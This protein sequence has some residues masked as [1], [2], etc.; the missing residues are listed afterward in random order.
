MRLILRRPVLW[1]TAGL[2]VAFCSAA[3][4]SGLA[5]P[6]TAVQPAPVDDARAPDR[7]DVHL[8]TTKGLIVIEAHRDW[9]P[10]G[11]DRF[12]TLVRAGYYDDSRFFRVVAD[13]WAQ[14]GI[15]GR[16]P[17]A[18]AWRTRTIPDDPPRQSNVKGAVAFA[19]AV[20][21]GRSTQV[22]INLRDNSAT[23]DKEPFAVFGRVARG[24]EVVEALHSAYGEASGGGIRAGK[25]APL[26][27]EGNAYLDRV[28]PQLDRIHRATIH[29]R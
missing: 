10:R 4:S 8:E 22:F 25:Q 11:A 23:L 20:A 16:P 13:R 29:A 18:Q 1:A 17:V 12:Y 24:M 6:S 28:Y 3:A 26:F 21:N 5:T 14:F 15:A 19:F 2:A 7:F 9:A 27:E